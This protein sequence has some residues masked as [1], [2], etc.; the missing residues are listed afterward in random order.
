MTTKTLNMKLH[1]IFL[2]VVY[3][4]LF[5]QNNK[6]C[7]SYIIVLNWCDNSTLYLDF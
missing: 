4:K 2:F 1:Q 3:L 5:K 6:T 7:R